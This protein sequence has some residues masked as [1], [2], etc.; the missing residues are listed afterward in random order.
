MTSELTIYQKYGPVAQVTL[1]R[2]EKLNALSVELT[3]QFRQRIEEIDRDPEI[4]VGIITG[5]GR[6]FCTG[7]DVHERQLGD[8]HDLAPGMDG[9][10][11]S[12][13]FLAKLLNWKPMIAAVAGPA[14]GGGL[15]LALNCELIVAAD[16]AKFQISQIH[17]GTSPVGLWEALRERCGETF[18]DDV[19]LTGRFWSAAE[20]L[21]R[22]MVNRVVSGDD[23]IA[24]AMEL[25]RSIAEKPPLAVQEVVRRRRIAIEKMRLDVRSTTSRN[26]RASKDFMESA[27]AFAEKRRPVSFIGS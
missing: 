24:S 18:A 5:A 9:G 19:T 13:D 10:Y 17:R 2:P 1:N 26:L 12:G 16:T 25:A 11:S 22:Q 23:L 15:G 27:A 4:R 8:R 7:T 3:R 6:A 21:E 14:V 20:A